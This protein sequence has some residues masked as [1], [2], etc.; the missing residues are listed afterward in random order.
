VSITLADA[1]IRLDAEP[2]RQV[3]P[4]LEVAMPGHCPGPANWRWLLDQQRMIELIEQAGYFD[5]LQLLRRLRDE[6]PVPADTDIVAL[7]LLQGIPLPLSSFSHFDSLFPE[8]FATGTRYQSRLAGNA[9]WLPAAVRD[10]FAATQGHGPQRLWV[11]PVSERLQ[12]EGFLPA[13]GTDWANGLLLGAFD[14]ALG[15]PE[16]GLIA[17]PDLE[18]LQIPAHLPDIPRLR[19]PNPPSS[20]LPCRSDYDDTHRERRHSSE[21]P[22]APEPRDFI[23][24]LHQLAGEIA[25]RRPDMH[26]LFTVPLDAEQKTESPRIS[27]HDLQKLDDLRNEARG[28]NLRRVQ[29]TFPYLRSARSSL[30]SA[31]GIIAAQMAKRTRQGAWLSTAGQ[32]LTDQARPYPP[33]DR[34]LATRLREQHALGVL[35]E[36]RGQVKLDDERLAAGVFGET[37]EH[38]RSGEVARFLGWLQREL[39]RLGEQ[40][41]FDI[42]PQDPR[43]RILLES[44]FGRLHAR[45]ALRGALPTDG[46]SLKQSAPNESTLLFEIELAPAFPIDRIRLSISRD[47]HDQGWQV[48]GLV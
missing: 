38:A 11:I 13:P 23:K 1:R 17:L 5:E 14:R 2:T 39:R 8:A 3:R 37:S 9:A 10:F 35:V 16:V 12:Q 47:G 45:G 32:P 15:L 48:G 7:T 21:I 25:L 19:L 4:A 40:L 41:V 30:K 46:F 22:R 34:N 27:P 42:D 29:L 28:R 44:F 31:C 18:R 20:F 26:L 6:K 24:T 36:E 43:P 33:V